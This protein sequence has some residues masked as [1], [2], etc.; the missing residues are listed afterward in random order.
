MAGPRASHPKTLPT[1]RWYGRCRPNSL[2][3]CWRGGSP[4]VRLRTLQKDAKQG[5]RCLRT[6]S[7]FR[8][9][10]ATR[11]KA[12]RR[13]EQSNGQKYGEEWRAGS[14]ARLPDR[15]CFVDRGARGDGG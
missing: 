15:G 13:K 5:R 11:H 3:F 7:K 9:E 8:P 1:E 6:I 14:V 2:R 10:A 12:A 4:T